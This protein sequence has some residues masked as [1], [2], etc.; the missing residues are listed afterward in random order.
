[1]CTMEN[2]K[3]R[4]RVFGEEIRKEGGI[5]RRQEPFCDKLFEIEFGFNEFIETTLNIG[6]GYE[7]HVRATF[8]AAFTLATNV[9]YTLQKSG[10]P[11]SDEVIGVTKGQLFASV[12]LPPDPDPD[13][14]ALLPFWFFYANI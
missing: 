14:F 6:N 1:M 4:Y 8:F 10:S 12:R 7:V 9:I 13:A 3:R 11:F 5:W 2:I